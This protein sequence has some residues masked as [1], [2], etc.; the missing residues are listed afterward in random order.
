MAREGAA[1]ELPSVSQGDLKQFLRISKSKD[2]SLKPQPL[3][4]KHKVGARPRKHG[5]AGGLWG[6]AAGASIPLGQVS[7]CT[8]V[9]L[10]M[11][12]LSNGRFVHRD[13]AARNCLVS[14][15]RQVKVSA[16]SLSKDVYNR[17]VGQGAGAGGWQRGGTAPTSL[18]ARP[19]C[20][21]RVLPLPPGLDPPALDAPR[22]CAGGRVLHQVGRLVLRR[23][24]VGGLH[25]RRD[26][27][28]PAGGR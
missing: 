25:A 13:L 1:S 14:A 8:Q 17:S 12:H 27:L 2:E 24:H 7:L 4:T 6:R 3:S 19:R 5:G 15:Q 9:A 22:S 20:P 26:A 23:A 28:Q 16:L 21:Q 10:G 18:T 11:E